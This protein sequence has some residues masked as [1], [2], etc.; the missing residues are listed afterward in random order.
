MLCLQCPRQKKKKKLHTCFADR[1][2]KSDMDTGE[3]LFTFAVNSATLAPSTLSIFCPDL[4]TQ[5]VIINFP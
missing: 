2:P 4:R 1:E 5:E 3:C